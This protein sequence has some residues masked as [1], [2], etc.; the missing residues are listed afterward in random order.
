MCKA[1]TSVALMDELKQ[2]L[3][4]KHAEMEGVKISV[5]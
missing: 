4:A 2:L 5:G 1:R 3:A